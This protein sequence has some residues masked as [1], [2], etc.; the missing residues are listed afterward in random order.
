MFL[1]LLMRMLYMIVGVNIRI[2]TF[3]H[4]RLEDPTGGCT[5]YKDCPCWWHA[6]QRASAEKK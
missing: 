2:E 6:E 5:G 4:Q 1:L 3:L